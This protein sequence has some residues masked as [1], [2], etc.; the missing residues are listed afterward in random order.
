M[1][2]S[3]LGGIAAKGLRTGANEFFYFKIVGETD[4]EY[5][6]RTGK[7]FEGGK[8]IKVSK[9]VY[10]SVRAKSPRSRWGRGK[11]M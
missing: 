11:S 5:S 10:H 8:T 3:D 9:G 6:L 2:L 1:T 7:W 4:K